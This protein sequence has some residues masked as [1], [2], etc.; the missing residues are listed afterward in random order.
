KSLPTRTGLQAGPLFFFLVR[1]GMGYAHTSP[2]Q[3]ENERAAGATFKWPCLTTCW[4]VRIRSLLY[5]MTGML[6]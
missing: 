3:K 2:H 1:R 5:H 4:L 6:N